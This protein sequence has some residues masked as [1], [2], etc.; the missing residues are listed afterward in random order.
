MEYTDRIRELEEENRRLREI[1]SENKKSEVWLQS[2]I[3][4]LPYPLFI[5]NTSRTFVHWN[6]EFSRI[7]NVRDE[8]F[9][10][11]T[12]FDLFE[13]EQAQ[14]F[15]DVDTQVLEENKTIVNEEDLTANGEIQHIIT[16]KT[17]ITDQEG[18]HYVLGMILDVTEIKRQEKLIK[19]KNK[20][21]LDSFRYAKRIQDTILPSADL[22]KK[23]LSQSFVLYMPKDFI[24]GDFYWLDAREDNVYFAAADC[25]GHGVPGAMISVICANAI[26]KV[27]SESSVTEPAEILDKVRELIIQK[28]ENSDFNVTDGMDISFCKVNLK[29]KKLSFSGAYNHLY[30]VARD[31]EGNLSHTKLLEYRGDKQPIG[32]FEKN[33]PFNQYDIQLDEGDVI[34]LSTDGYPDQFGGER[35]KKLKQRPFKQLLHSISNE[36]MSKQKEILTNYFD[37]WKQDFDQIDD[38]CVIGVRF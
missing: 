22:I 19:K 30:R 37:S 2:I 16:T 7:T 3:D 28:F 9:I 4:K 18:N 24:A 15:W 17:R 25:T 31:E 36:K 5:K 12:D 11:S 14:V 23:Y 34:Y 20:E 13:K 10:G 32:K 38:V 6:K 33:K 1:I 35:G 27:F 26:N 21:I 8:D 29:T